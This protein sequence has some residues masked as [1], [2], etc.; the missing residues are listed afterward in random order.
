MLGVTIFAI[1]TWLL[2]GEKLASLL[3]PYLV[4]SLYLRWG[5][6]MNKQSVILSLL[7]SCSSQGSTSILL[8][9]KGVVGALAMK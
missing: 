5:D 6:S 1:F 7:L 3:F 9:H 8:L 2:E 4:D